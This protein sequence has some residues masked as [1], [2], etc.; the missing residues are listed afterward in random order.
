MT[1]KYADVIIDISHEA[2]DKVFQYR[3]PFS[4]QGEIRPGVRVQ[5][6][7]G[8][9]NQV[10]E[11]YVISLSETADYPEDLIKE[12]LALSPGSVA[13]ESQMI[14][15]AAFLK[16]R[17]G[18]SMY[19]ALKTVMPV[20]KTVARKK[21]TDV[22]LRLTV[23]EA[24]EILRLWEK[25]NYRVR[26]RFLAALLQRPDHTLSGDEIKQIGSISQKDLKKM[27]EQGIITL[28]NRMLY[29]NPFSSLQKKEERVPLNLEQS[30]VLEEFTGDYEAGE[31]KTYLLHGVTGSGKT[32]VYMALIEV[33]LGMGK[34]AIVLIPEISL[35]FQTVRRF[36]ERF[37]E[38]VAVIHSRMSQGEKSD[39]YMRIEQGEANIVVGPRSALF[40]PTGNLGL[41]V[42][43]EEHDGA[44]KSDSTPK[45]HARET[46]I[47]RAGMTGAS[48][49]LGSATP[50]M[51][52]YTRA[53]R[54][55][56][57][58][59]TLK[60]RGGDAVLPRVSIV[61]LKEEFHQG[62]RSVFSASLREKIRERLER[63]EQ[64]M[65]FL[66]RRG[67][68]GFV[69]C[70]ACGTVIKC[71][72]CDI[73]LT[74][75]RDGTLRC[76]YCGF[77]SPY[78]RECPVCRRPHVAAFGLG[79]EKVETA[80]AE[81]F[82]GARVLRMD[83]DT[84]RRKHSHQKMLEAFGGGQADILLG[85]Q[86]IVKGHDYENVTLV[87]ILAADLSLHSHDFRSGERTFQLLC[88]AA[89]RAGRG[90]KQ[91]E[92]V[93]QTYSPD[94]Y[95]I[96]TAADQDYYRFYEE[97]AAYRKMLRYPPWSHMLVILVQS[98]EESQAA[99]AVQR[100]QKMI[101]QS[102][103]GSQNPVSVLNPGQ[104]SLAKLKDTYRQV[105]YLKHTE[106]ERLLD[107]KDRLQ[108]VIDTHPLFAGVSVQYD[109]DPMN[110]Y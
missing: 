40:A 91:G 41:I 21:K 100:I 67:F 55:E 84:T 54:G 36:Y 3:V 44:Y 74:Y 32:E 71:P 83:M 93:I 30:A 22:T 97:E 77:S 46:A 28:Q 70:R 13:M 107:L 23:P 18:S 89:G 51:E 9:G 92:V 105:I 27:E 37:G 1:K 43:D 10:R 69:S 19:Q 58:L 53:Q 33:V 5:I 96:R 86:M 76:H 20:K 42:I 81:E 106:A 2:L 85:T 26:S 25:R 49:V 8:K 50:S 72:H 12:I 60:K 98:G 16:D 110:S 80:L 109:F 90:K 48:V 14:R 17:Y 95:A 35:T 15:L 64:I 7:F 56:Y 99:L 103:S 45:Y 57:T 61:D 66:N 82:P 75:H 87:G 59:W 65:L 68:A 94:H 11:G 38:Q 73:S 104:A 47:F 39:S 24:E 52:S 6:P 31:R 63:K 102:Q 78:S 4:L 62:N 88:Q 108:A 79:T 34:Q 29:R 101:V